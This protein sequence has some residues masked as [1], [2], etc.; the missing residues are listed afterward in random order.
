MLEA[1]LLSQRPMSAMAMNRHAVTRTVLFFAASRWLLL[2]ALGS[3][4]ESAQTRPKY[5]D[6]ANQIIDFFHIGDRRRSWTQP[7]NKSVL[8]RHVQHVEDAY[9]VL[10]PEETTNV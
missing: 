2:H 3:E 1:S 6:N 7:N 10:A 8:I 9:I 5:G 4:F